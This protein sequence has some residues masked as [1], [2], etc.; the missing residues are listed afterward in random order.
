MKGGKFID[1]GTPAEIYLRSRNEFSAEFMGR[2]NVVYGEVERRATGRGFCLLGTLRSSL[3]CPLPSGAG[4]GDRRAISVRP[5]DIRVTRRPL[6]GAV[7]LR[8]GTVRAV[9][10]QR[11]LMDCQVDVREGSRRMRLYPS[12]QFIAG[13]RV[14][15][16]ISPERCVAI[17]MHTD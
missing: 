14:Y 10:F 9:M 15:L 6:D 17:R 12:A 16:E 11:E 13:E 5:E 1:Q 4:G 2:T 8:E 3:F 7:N